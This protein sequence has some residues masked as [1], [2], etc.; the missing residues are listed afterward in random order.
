MVL[1]AVLVVAA[2]LYRL[3]PH[4]QNFAPLS[5]IALCGGLFLS[6]RNSFWIVLGMMVFTD[7][8][9]NIFKW[10]GQYGL[11]PVEVFGHYAG[12]LIA[13]ALG[14]RLRRNSA[15]QG[16]QEVPVPAVL[17]STI[18]ASA[19][20][21]LVTNFVSWLDNPAYPKTLAGLWQSYTIGLPGYP[22]TLVFFG[23]TLASDL[24]FVA[25]FLA[26]IQLARRGLPETRF[27]FLLRPA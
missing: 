16:R 17:G 10:H 5:A 3:A 25:L 8:T 15:S 11:F 22:S 12:F 14:W 7:L 23:R 1:A 6:R 27:S 24:A 20:F 19:L 21:F 9:E 2:A 13:L 18:A 4:P 26:V